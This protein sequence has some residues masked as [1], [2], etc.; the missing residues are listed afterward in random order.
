VYG[1]GQRRGRKIW[2]YS[3]IWTSSRKH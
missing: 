2:K 3:H 1:E